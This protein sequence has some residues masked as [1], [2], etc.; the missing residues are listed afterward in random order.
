VNIER[1][2]DDRRLKPV[3]GSHL[4]DFTLFEIPEQAVWCFD[5]R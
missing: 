1:N 5:W 4:L 2:E 3:I